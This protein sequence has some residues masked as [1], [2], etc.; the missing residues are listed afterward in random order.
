MGT[1]L[2]LVESPLDEG[3]EYVTGVDMI[4][5]IIIMMKIVGQSVGPIVM[6]NEQQGMK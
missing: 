6:F 3:G 4:I 2:C 5:I 1:R